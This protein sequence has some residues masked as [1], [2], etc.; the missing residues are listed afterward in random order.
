EE[1]HF[2]GFRVAEIFKDCNEN[3]IPDECDLDCGATIGT[4]GVLCS[5]VFPDPACGQSSDTDGDGAQDE[6]DNCPSQPNP[7]QTDG[8]G[9]GVGDECDTCPGYDDAQPCPIPTVSQWGLAVMTLL[10]LTAGGLVITRRRTFVPEGH[11][12]SWV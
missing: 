4:T 3:G 12:G 2:A 10:V 8:D 1:Y 7:T 11:P 5:D 6:C 9:D